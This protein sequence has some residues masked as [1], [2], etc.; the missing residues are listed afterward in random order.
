[1]KPMMMELAEE[2]EMLGLSEPV[3]EE[4]DRTY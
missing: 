2:G 1:M 4:F 3:D